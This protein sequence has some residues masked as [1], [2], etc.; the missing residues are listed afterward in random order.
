MRKSTPPKRTHAN[1][2]AVRSGPPRARRARRRRAASSTSRGRKARIVDKR[3]EEGRHLVELALQVDNQ[4][5]ETTA[6]GTAV[7]ELPAR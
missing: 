2:C 1:S 6:E 3:V 4:L 5:G 7:V